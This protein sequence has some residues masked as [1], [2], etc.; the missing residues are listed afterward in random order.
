M[1]TAPP[2]SKVLPPPFKPRTFS[3]HLTSLLNRLQPPQ[4]AL[5]L[6]AAL[7]I[8]GS[9]GLAMVLFHILI[10]LCE[11]LSFVQI[12]EYLSRWSTWA[13]ACI[14]ISGGIVLGL[15]R[16]H[17][18]DVLGQG[19]NT[20]LSSTRSQTVSLLRPII[21]MLA[22]IV[23]LGTG[24]SLG[25]E[26]PS[27]E[28]GANVGALLG[29]TFQVSKER[30][31]LLLGA[32]A[33]AGLAAG[34]NAPITG[35][36]FALEVVLVPTFTTPAISL[37]LLSAVVSAVVSRSFLGA[38]PAFELP[39]YEVL[40][41]WEW[42][43]YLGLGL[44]ASVVSTLFIE[45]TQLAQAGFQGN[46]PGLTWVKRIPEGIKPIVGGACV[47]IT[48]LQLPQILGVGYGTMET[49]FQGDFISLPLLNLLL[50]AKIGLTAISLGS[51]LVGGIF[52]PAMLL[53]VCMGAIYG[54]VLG[55]LLPA[56]LVD[57]APP[58]AY[59]IVGMAAV[60]GGSARAPLTAVILLFELTRNYQIIPPAMA[61]VG[62][63]VWMVDQIGTGHWIERLN[64]QQMGINLEK[65]EY[66]DV[67]Q[68]IST[69]FLLDQS[70][71]S[72]PNSTPLLEVGQ[73]M[74]EHKCHTALVLDDAQELAGIIT[75]SDIR[76]YIATALAHKPTEPN[77]EAVY[78]A[79]SQTLKN[80]CTLEVV[81]AYS[82][83][84]VI[85]V[86]E[87][88]DTRGL[89]LL[90][91]V[92]PDNPR[93]ILGV[94]DRHRISLASDLVGT[95]QALESYLKGALVSSGQSTSVWYSLDSSN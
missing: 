82:N 9:T 52:A 40:S 14:P 30:Y 12:L 90:P 75:L 94:I 55:G 26:G 18:P 36:F 49:I 16:W 79:L 53:G 91:V 20:M 56:D 60:L 1:T 35:V 15:M 88:M 81:Y 67:L 87:R 58:P 61:A 8:G 92:E 47:G 29:Q 4:E 50:F 78:Q 80:V 38:H 7:V 62:M 34:F 45:A 25:P 74:V 66:P 54:Q 57:I 65:Q 48:A 5:M 33:A 64:L 46:L 22:A 42:L 28:I 23:S 19:F 11:Y 93:K 39:A 21:K 89:Y 13:L 17:Y 68:Q 73:A 44:L 95:Q 86:L 43:L 27:V 59:A 31:R 2:G 10:D 37:I 84:P 72:L 3:E 24:A 76:R 63:S 77:P 83:E 51:G 6:L 32:G 70:Y 41:H 71:L 85:D 69:A